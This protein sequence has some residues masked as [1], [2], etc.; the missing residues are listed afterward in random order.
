M[1]S[2]TLWTYSMFTLSLRPLRN[3][4]PLANLRHARS[5]N[6]KKMDCR[7]GEF[8]SM[9]QYIALPCYSKTLIFC[10]ANTCGGSSVH[11]STHHGRATRKSELRRT[12]PTKSAGILPSPL[13]IA[14]QLIRRCTNSSEFRGKPVVD[15][16][17]PRILAVR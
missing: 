14:C 7:S 17:A 12:S 2:G 3:H 8:Y 15:D 5:V 13:P 11:A 10:V 6:G 4:L 9:C 1:A 16:S